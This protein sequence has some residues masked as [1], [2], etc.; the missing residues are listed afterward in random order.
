MDPA[1]SIALEA[2]RGY[3]WPPI[4]YHFTQDARGVLL[5]IP[6]LGVQGTGS[7]T[8][9]FLL[10]VDSSRPPQDSVRTDIAFSMHKEDLLKLTRQE[11]ETVI[12]VGL[13]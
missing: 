5:N 6:N 1:S 4:E 3:P 2:P 7:V 8:L 13:P 11:A 10:G 9:E 12:E